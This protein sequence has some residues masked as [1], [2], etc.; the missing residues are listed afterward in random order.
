MYTHGHYAQCIKKTDCKLC[1]IKYVVVFAFTPV[2]TTI[3]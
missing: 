2:H 3:L 1:C